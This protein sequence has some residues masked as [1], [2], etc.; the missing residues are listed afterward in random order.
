MSFG[1]LLDIVKNVLKGI[2]N[3][4]LE[5]NPDSLMLKIG[6]KI[7][8]SFKTGIANGMKGVSEQTKAEIEK[9]ETQRRLGVKQRELAQGGG[10]SLIP[11]ALKGVNNNKGFFLAPFPMVKPKNNPKAEIPA[12]PF[13]GTSRGDGKGKSIGD[14][15]GINKTVEGTK[16]TV[17]NISFGTITGVNQLTQTGNNMTNNVQ[18]IGDKV[19]EHVIRRITSSVAIAQ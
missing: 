14:K 8:S 12:P 4:F 7:G 1:E 17:I 16:P 3:L 18:E 19:V 15:S 2:I 6:E 13:G 9:A 10:A 5:Y 11:S